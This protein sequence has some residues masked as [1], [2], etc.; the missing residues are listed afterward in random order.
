MSWLISGWRD[1]LVP[2]EVDAY[3]EGLDLDV[4]EFKAWL[5]KRVGDY[6]TDKNLSAQF[7]NASTEKA[8]L[9]KFISAMEKTIS[10]LKPHGLPPRVNAEFNTHLIKSTDIDKHEKNEDMVETLSIYLDLAKKVQH[11]FVNARSPKGRKDRLHEDLF[12][13]DVVVK[14]QGAGATAMEAR[15]RAENILIA[16]RITNVPEGERSIRRTQ[17][18][19]RTTIE[20]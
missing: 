5:S 20:K 8:E 6:R 9:K 17:R 7:P 14:L 3:L 1:D 13:N 4:K 11:T 19:A 15:G 18:R 2:K 10:F 16:L 12:L